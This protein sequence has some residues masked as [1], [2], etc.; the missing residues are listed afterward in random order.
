V[1]PFL[2]NISLEVC[3]MFMTIM[4]C[5]LWVY[6]G[7]FSMMPYVQRG[8]IKTQPDIRA[9]YLYIFSWCLLRA[10]HCHHLRHSAISKKSPSGLSF[11]VFQL[12]MD[13]ASLAITWFGFWG[14]LKKP[15]LLVSTCHVDKTK[16]MILVWC[17]QHF[18]TS[19]YLLSLYALRNILQYPFLWGLHR[20]GIFH[21]GPA[22]SE[23]MCFT[24][25]N[26]PVSIALHFLVCLP[27]CHWLFR[28]LQQLI[29]NPRFSL[30]ENATLNM[31]ARKA[32]LINVSY[33]FLVYG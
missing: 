24:V 10:F 11:A 27:A 31:W 2:S 22:A 9:V 18:Q 26:R 1:I 21:Y 3:L 16:C 5:H 8:Y 19:G 33:L 20:F 15:V 13:H 29:F 23:E 25:L 32:I 4:G 28:C 14:M 12:F 6:R 17:F 30:R 7:V